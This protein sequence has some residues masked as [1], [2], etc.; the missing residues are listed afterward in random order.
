M[1]DELERRG[2]K[3]KLVLPLITHHSL[4]ITS[5]NLPR[6]ASFDLAAGFVIEATP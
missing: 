5:S 2:E 4:L 6:N 3:L 1:S